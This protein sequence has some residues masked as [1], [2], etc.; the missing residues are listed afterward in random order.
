MKEGEENIWSCVK[1]RASASL[2]W[3]LHHGEEKQ[4]VCRPKGR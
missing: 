1:Q 4:E 3:R 2:T